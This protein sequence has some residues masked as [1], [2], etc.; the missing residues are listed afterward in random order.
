MFH[1]FILTFCDRMNH[2]QTEGQFCYNTSDQSWFLSDSTDDR[3]THFHRSRKSCSEW[4]TVNW[5][6]G[7][8]WRSK[9]GLKVLYLSQREIHSLV[10]LVTVLLRSSAP[11]S[12]FLLHFTPLCFSHSL[13]VRVRLISQTYWQ[14][15]VVGWHSARALVTSPE[16]KT[17]PLWPESWSMVCAE[18]GLADEEPQSDWT[19]WPV[20]TTG[21]VFGWS[22]ASFRGLTELKRTADRQPVK[23]DEASWARSGSKSGASEER[24]SISSCVSLC[25][26]CFPWKPQLITTRLC[27]DFRIQTWISR[28]EKKKKKMLFCIWF[29]QRATKSSFLKNI[30]YVA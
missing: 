3:L 5:P 20:M 28:G 23:P 1:L 21:L 10:T 13:W 30:W 7:L 2:H 29:D 17:S 27:L 9:I 26:L 16:K 24:G 22:K 12:L 6:N 25:L 14:T 4:E 19:S 8:R 18:C 11:A 15:I